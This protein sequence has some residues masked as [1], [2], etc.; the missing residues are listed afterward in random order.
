MARRREQ[1]DKKENGSNTQPF[2]NKNSRRIDF[3]SFFI[4]RATLDELACIS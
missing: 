3:G 2:I 4:S 1:A